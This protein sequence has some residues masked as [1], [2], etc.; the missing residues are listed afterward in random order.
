MFFVASTAVLQPPEKTI[1]II[2]LSYKYYVKQW[3]SS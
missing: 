3:S 1:D 2:K